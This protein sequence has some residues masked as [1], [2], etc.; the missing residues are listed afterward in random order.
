MNT[1]KLILVDCDGVLLDYEA[2]FREWM[3]ELGYHH[4]DLPKREYQFHHHFLDLTE[5]DATRLCSFYNRSE[6][7]GHLKPFRQSN[8]FVQKLHEELGFK[9]RVL[10]SFGGDSWSRLRREALLREHFGNAIESVVFLNFGESKESE[11][12]KYQDSGFWWIEDLPKNADTGYTLGLRSV[13]IEHYY[14][15]YHICN[16]PVVPD[17][18]QVYR[19]IKRAESGL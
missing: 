12:K 9:F 1:K 17:W 5:D 15:S 19:V 11:L 7:V 14:N 4:V 3:E 16:Y 2:G 6:A 18:E 10:T 13:L 8:I